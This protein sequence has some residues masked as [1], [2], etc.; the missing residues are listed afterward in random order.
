M[1][2]RSVSGNKSGHSRIL[3]SEEEKTQEICRKVGADIK[4]QEQMQISRSRCMEAKG[5]L[6]KLEPF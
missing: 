6:E 5:D 4:K 1:K 3:K 2:R